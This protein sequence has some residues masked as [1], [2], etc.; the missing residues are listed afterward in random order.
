MHIWNTGAS[1]VMV[2]PIYTDFYG[3]ISLNYLLIFNFVYLNM[4]DSALPTS[5]QNLN[6]THLFYFPLSLLINHYKLQGLN[7]FL[8]ILVDRNLPSRSSGEES[9]CFSPSSWWLWTTCGIPWL[10]AISLQTLCVPSR[11]FPS[12]SLCL[13][14]V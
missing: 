1:G 3:D 4:K 2:I 7:K 5:L 6:V 11:D 8:T 14:F 9:S 10:A 12:I 13:H